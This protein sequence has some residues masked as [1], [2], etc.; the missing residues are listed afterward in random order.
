MTEREER[1]GATNLIG[2]SAVGSGV[3]VVTGS[4]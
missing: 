4:L 2:S 3:V 1:V